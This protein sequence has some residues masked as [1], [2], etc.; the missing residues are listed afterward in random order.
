MDYVFIMQHEY[1]KKVRM[2][3]TFITL[4]L[5]LLLII[6]LYIRVNG[7]GYY[8]Y[9]A[10]E[11]MHTN[12]ASAHSLHELFDDA[13][14]ETHPPLLYFCVHY[15]LQLSSET[16]FVRCLPLVFGIATLV[17]YYCIGAKLNNQMTGITSAVIAAFSNGL[18]I[19]SYTVRHY[20]L[21]VFFLTLAFYLYLCWRQKRNYSLLAAYGVAGWL[22]TISHFSAIFA[23]FT[24]TL[25]E[26]ILLVREKEKYKP[27]LLW[28]SINALIAACYLPFVHWWQPTFAI[29]EQYF[30]NYL[31]SDHF[32]STLLYVPIILVSLLPHP[33]FELSVVMLVMLTGKLVQGGDVAF[34]RFFWLPVLAVALGLLL[35]LLNIYPIFGMLSWRRNL[36]VAPFIIALAG[37]L[38]AETIGLIKNSNLL[39]F[40]PFVLIVLAF[41]AYNPIA[42]F[43]DI[44]E[45]VMPAKD[46]NRLQAYTDTLNDDTLL[47]AERDDAIMLKNLYPYLGQ[48]AFVKEDMAIAIPYKNTSLLLNP[49]Y[50]RLLDKQVFLETMHFAIDHAMLKENI[51]F[52]NT[53]F[54]GIRTEHYPVADLILCSDLPKEIIVIPALAANEQLTTQNLY[55]HNIVLARVTRDDL[56]NNFLN[57]NGKAHHCLH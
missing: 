24:L 3:K 30:H 25:Y 31:Y 12:I 33:S 39:K 11:F 1:Y 52:F 47:F 35:N 40:A 28:L 46:F 6:A 43:S 13:L 16:W 50:R 17:L 18:I 27:L 5:V 9:N 54:S 2:S 57:E 53:K 42:R 10:D 49:F 36:W 37:W 15:W 41:A 51:V 44:S 8:A 26:V 14:F 45:Y 56:V 22:A 21:M 38:L 4:W 48:K 20:A 23:I 32:K 34:K 55:E 29:H 7:A 19:Q